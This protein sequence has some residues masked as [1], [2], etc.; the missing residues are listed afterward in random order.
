[1]KRILLAEDEEVLRMLVVD[2]LEGTEGLKTKLHSNFT[3]GPG[4]N[5]SG[6]LLPLFFMDNG[7][8]LNSTRI[9]RHY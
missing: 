6:F 4:L 7:T 1:M 9:V 3:K 5:G 8:R 2:T